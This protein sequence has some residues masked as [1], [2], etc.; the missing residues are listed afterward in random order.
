MPRPFLAAT[1]LLFGLPGLALLSH[2]VPLG[3]VS[4]FGASRLMGATETPETPPL[5]L[6]AVLDGR[7]QAKLG[8]WLAAR[9]GRPR[10][11]YIRVNNGLAYLFRRPSAPGIVFGRGRT[12][13]EA[14]YVEEWCRRS[15]GPDTDRLAGRLAKL[16]ARLRAEGRAFVFLISPSKAAVYPDLLPPGCDPPPEPRPVERLRAALA[17]RGVRVIDGS[18]ILSDARRRQPWPVFGRDGTHWN[19]LGAGYVSMELLAEA[20][21]QLGRL[22][23]RLELESVRVDRKPFAEERDLALLLNLPID[24]PT[25]PSPHPRYRTLPQPSP[26]RTLIVGSSFSWQITRLFAETG[27]VG[28]SRQYYYFSR[29]R[30]FGNGRLA[31]EG[32][33]FEAARDLPS[34]LAVTDWVILEANEASFGSSHVEAFI[35]AVLGLGS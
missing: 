3:P 22:V 29:V 23:S 30:L 13:F 15:P 27:V 2:G 17:E 11:A 16:Q 25:Y 9:M 28:A 21:R 31:P 19:V 35:D 26:P 20:E 1:A 7:L 12:L 24:L 32:P 33:P 14:E 34:A 8:P 4:Q 10:E 5:S 18:A 6:G